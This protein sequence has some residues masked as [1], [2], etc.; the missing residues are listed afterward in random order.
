[1]FATI[2]NFLLESFCPML[3]SHIVDILASQKSSREV[4]GE[5]LKLA[6]ID[7]CVFPFSLFTLL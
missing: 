4:L 2:Y 6:P 5:S 3:K 7:T 1:M